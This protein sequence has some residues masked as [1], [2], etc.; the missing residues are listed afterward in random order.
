[1]PE[2]AG[3]C[4]GHEHEAANEIGDDHHPSP[5]PPIGDDPAVE[6]EDDCRNA[7]G[8]ADRD[9]TKRATRDEGEPHESDVLERVAEL[10][11]RNRPVRA[12]E[13]TPPKERERGLGS[14]RVF[15]AGRRDLGRHR[16]SHLEIGG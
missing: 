5:V 13:I 7:V 9:H 12:S 3:D 1:V 16:F 10:A 8:E 6:P 15:R 4:N 2:E 11:D 14:R